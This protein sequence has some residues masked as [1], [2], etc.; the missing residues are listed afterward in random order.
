[1]KS[2]KSRLLMVLTMLAMLIALSV[3]V[4]AQDHNDGWC[5]GEI[6]D[7]F[8]TVEAPSGERFA[9]LLGDDDWDEL[10][11][12]LWYLEELGYTVVDVD[13]VCEDGTVAGED[14]AAVDED[15]DEDEDED[16]DEDDDGIPDWLD[17]RDDD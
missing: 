9:F 4:I 8:I 7:Y 10:V 14:S 3:P 1:M 5:G 17:D 12:A 16:G 6:E 2:W 15:S 11:A 13:P